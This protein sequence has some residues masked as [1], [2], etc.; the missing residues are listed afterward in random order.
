[1]PFDRSTN[2]YVT[3]PNPCAHV[4]SPR[5]PVEHPWNSKCI[6]RTLLRN[7]FFLLRYSAW[8]DEFRRRIHLQ[9]RCQTLIQA[10]NAETQRQW[11]SFH[12]AGWGFEMQRLNGCWIIGKN[13]RLT[14]LI[15]IPWKAT[16]AL[17]EGKTCKKDLEKLRDVADAL[18][19]LSAHQSG[20]ETAWIPESKTKSS[21][22]KIWSPCGNKNKWGLWTMLV[23]YGSLIGFWHVGRWT[24]HFCM[25]E[26][27]LAS[28]PVSI[29]PMR[30]LP[31]FQR[32]FSMKQ[33]RN[34][35]ATM[36]G[37]K[38]ETCRQQEMPML[39]EAPR[40]LRHIFANNP[41]KSPKHNFIC[42]AAAWR[43]LASA[44]AQVLEQLDSV[45]PRWP[46]LGHAPN[47]WVEVRSR[48]LRKVNLQQ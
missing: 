47:G 1:M 21:T 27:P 31:N 17:I 28:I 16:P 10:C 40:V 3:L 11:S 41:M 37:T 38:W 12:Q 4:I 36:I 15:R 44:L 5:D 43:R 45:N 46:W 6:T 7:L 25:C 8:V 22:Y 39:G 23:L 19:L 32:K 34:V 2:T 26:V 30:E 33:C 9:Q 18:S 42:Q 13:Q 29:L 48:K 35:L 24:T 14:S 20:N